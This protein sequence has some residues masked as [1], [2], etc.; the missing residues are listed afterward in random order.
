V[1][2]CISPGRARNRGVMTLPSACSIRDRWG[3][4][5]EPG[6]VGCQNSAAPLTS[7]STSPRPRPSGV[8]E[9]RGESHPLQQPQYALPEL[10]QCAL[11]GRQPPGEFPGQQRDRVSHPTG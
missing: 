10:R 9:L 1:S 4:V 11:W 5:H 6:P 3:C 8:F 7:G 2:S